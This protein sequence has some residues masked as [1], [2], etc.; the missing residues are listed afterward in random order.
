MF[1][2]PF[3]KTTRNLLMIQKTQKLQQYPAPTN[4]FQIIHQLKHSLDNM[5][6]DNKKTHPTP[7][8]TAM[9]LCV[10]SDQARQTL[11]EM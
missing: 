10:A 6:A 2:I 9:F 7:K 5:F 11:Y 3:P 8:A 4:L 1:T